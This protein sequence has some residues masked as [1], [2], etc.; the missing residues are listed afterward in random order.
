[1]IRS[2]L[3]CAS[4]MA[5]MSCSTATDGDDGLSLDGTIC[6]SGDRGHRDRAGQT[7]QARCGMIITA[8]IMALMTALTLVLLGG[9]ML[10][11][12][13]RPRVLLRR[14]FRQASLLLPGFMVP[15]V[16]LVRQMAHFQVG[17][18]KLPPQGKLH[19]R[20]QEQRDALDAARRLVIENP[21]DI[22][23]RFALP[24]QRPSLALRRSRSTLSII[25]LR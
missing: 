9:S 8:I 2:S 16:H 14:L 20:S 21:D 4:D 1:M 7:T 25:S 15:S 3:S 12:K 6:L 13:D 22:E 23:A 24:K 5:I 11:G 10:R 19:S 17:V 18:K